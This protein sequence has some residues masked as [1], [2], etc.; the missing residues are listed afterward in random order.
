MG[1]NDFLLFGAFLRDRWNQHTYGP[2]FLL[3][4]V[5]GLILGFFLPRGD[6]IPLHYNVYFGIDLIDSWKLSFVLPIVGLSL[7]VI[8]ILVAYFIWKIDKEMSRFISLGTVVVLS[9]IVLASVLSI[10][11]NV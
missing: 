7:I 2:A 4:I 6:F 10:Y 11:L 8:N 9:I 5:T 1:D 3:C